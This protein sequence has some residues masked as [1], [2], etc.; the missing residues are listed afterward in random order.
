MKSKA[1]WKESLLLT[2]KAL[3]IK[4]INPIKTQLK[5]YN[6]ENEYPYEL[7]LLINGS[8]KEKAFIGP[9]TNPFLPW[10]KELEISQVLDSHM[11]I[12][13]KYPVQLGHMLL[14]SKNWKSQSSWLDQNDFKALIN[15]NKDTTGLWFFNS[16]P[17]AGASQPHRHLQLLPRNDKEIICPSQVWIKSQIEKVN[18]NNLFFNGSMALSSISNELSDD[19]ALNLYN[20]YVNL[21]DRLNIGVPDKSSKP[22]VPYNILLSEDWLII[23][24]RSRESAFGFEI[25]ALGFA[26]YLLATNIS[27][28]NWLE[29]NGLYSLLNQVIER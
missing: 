21:C 8:F 16:S 19:S 12:L 22:L 11:L 23:V 9:K 14:I 28:I 13:N 2:E 4:S 17:K 6:K 3:Q 7:R 10:E 20:L 5:I 26:G 18:H 29:K 15:V 24:K 25:N 27:N 1:F